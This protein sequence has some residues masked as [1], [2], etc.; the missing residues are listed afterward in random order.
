MLDKPKAYLL[1]K[2]P[3][4][5]CGMPHTQSCKCIL[6][7]DNWLSAWNNLLSA[8]QSRY[9]VTSHTQFS[10][11]GKRFSIVSRFPLLALSASCPCVDGSSTSQSTCR[12]TLLLSLLEIA[13][14]SGGS[15]II[16]NQ[17]LHK[18]LLWIHE[19]KTETCI[20]NGTY[21]C[22]DDLCLSYCIFSFLLLILSNGQHFMKLSSF[23][24]TF[25]LDK[26]IS[27]W[28]T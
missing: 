8:P 3:S 4:H 18:R 17:W 16:K 14:S 23:G 26:S 12:M 9:P 15:G 21:Q 24:T 22:P 10:Q 27:Y 2:L 13:V 11:Y 7:I 28:S 25:N 6:F 19:L 1:Q 20:Q 5:L